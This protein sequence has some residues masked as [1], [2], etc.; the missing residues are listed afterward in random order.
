MIEKGLIIGFVILY[1]AIILSFRHQSISFGREML[2]NQW[3]FHHGMLESY[4]HFYAGNFLFLSSLIAFYIIYRNF[5]GSKY[6]WKTTMTGILAIGLIGFGESNDHIFKSL[7]HDFLHYMHLVGIPIAIYFLL[8]G[9]KEY[10]EQFENGIESLSTKKISLIFSGYFIACALIAFQ[11]QVVKG[12]LELYFIYLIMIPVLF[13]SFL[14]LR[15]AKRAYKEYGILM[16]NIPALAIVLT[17]N[18]LDILLGRYASIIQNGWLYVLTH[19]IQDILLVVLGTI[20]LVFG[21]ATS[22]L[23]KN[24]RKDLFADWWIESFEKRVE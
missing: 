20:L 22:T 13:L 15:E 12:R 24:L 23:S 14:L 5:K 21:L 3:F 18:G 8:R 10:L 1:S 4:V 19:A 7:G 6:G 17:L 16:V 2:L 9:L 11:A